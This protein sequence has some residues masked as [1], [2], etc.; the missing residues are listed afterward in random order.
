MS[1]SKPRT[2]AKDPIEKQEAASEAYTLAA[3]ELH[4]AVN[5]ALNLMTSAR[6]NPEK[7]KYLIKSLR[8]PNKK[9]WKAFEKLTTS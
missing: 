7:L 4:V 9:L 1:I 5:T 3:M 8:K 2:R 6:D